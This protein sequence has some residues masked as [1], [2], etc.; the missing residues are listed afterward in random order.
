MHLKI[1]STTCAVH[2]QGYTFS[3]SI[4]EEI[5]WNKPCKIKRANIAYLESEKNVWLL[6]SLK[7][8][9]FIINSL[10]KYFPELLRLDVSYYY[11]LLGN[12]TDH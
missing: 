12:M 2:I 1:T 5:E 7:A 11:T 10:I 6:S 9:R 4:Q 3:R 8:H